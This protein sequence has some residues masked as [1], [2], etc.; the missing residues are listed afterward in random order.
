MKILSVFEQPT[1]DAYTYVVTVGGLGT[2]IACYRSDGPLR[3]SAMWIAHH[4][5]KLTKAEF[6]ATYGAWDYEADGFHYRR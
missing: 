3:A 2:D 5:H 1:R 6:D 4:G